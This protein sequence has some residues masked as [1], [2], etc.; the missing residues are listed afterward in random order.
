MFT[1]KGLGGRAK[2]SPTLS[3]FTA[4]RSAMG[5]SSAPTA[6][7]PVSVETAAK[8]PFQQKKFSPFPLGRELGGSHK[9][10]VFFNVVKKLKKSLLIFKGKSTALLPNG[11]QNAAI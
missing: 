10:R 8:P 6:K 11:A 1:R 2:L 5:K 7:N 4:I 3:P 9:G